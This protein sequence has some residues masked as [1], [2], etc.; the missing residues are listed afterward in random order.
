MSGILQ[1]LIP[2]AAG[3]AVGLTVGSVAIKAPAIVGKIGT[4]LYE[5]SRDNIRRRSEV[6]DSLRKTF[7]GDDFDPLYQALGEYA[8][9]LDT[10]NKIKENPA[11]TQ[12]A[13]YEASY[14]LKIAEDAIRKVPEIVRGGF[15]AFVEHVALVTQSGLITYELANYEFGYYSILCWDCDPFWDGMDKSSPYWTLYASFVEQLRVAA[16]ALE[17][18]PSE[19]IAKLRF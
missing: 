1:W 19:E 14:K 15:A 4:F 12:N 7:D 8:N 18:N 2:S 13:I 10:L 3:G 11:A 16:K 17:S 6:Y 9:V 5:Y